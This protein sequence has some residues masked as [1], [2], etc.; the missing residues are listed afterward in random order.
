MNAFLCIWLMPH[1]FLRWDG[2]GGIVM[3]GWLR[4]KGVGLGCHI[5][6]NL[7]QVL[8]LLAWHDAVKQKGQ[9]QRIGPIQRAWCSMLK[10]INVTT[11]ARACQS[12]RSTIKRF[13]HPMT[14]LVSLKCTCYGINLADLQKKNS[15]FLRNN[16][17]EPPSC[18][19][20]LDWHPWIFQEPFD[21]AQG[22]LSPS[23]LSN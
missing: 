10:Q 13:C 20:G 12:L 2:G 3:V 21:C 15:F 22:C 19:S 17:V 6:S 8:H 23:S 16:W 14:Y 7:C 9:S 11:E 18:L 1:F 5:G 4:W